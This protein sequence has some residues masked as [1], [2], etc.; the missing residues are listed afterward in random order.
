MKLEDVVKW[1]LMWKK[2]R[3][4]EYRGNRPQYRLW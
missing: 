1:K 3:Q 2:L 4:W